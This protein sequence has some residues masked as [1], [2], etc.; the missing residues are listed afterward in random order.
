[1]KIYLTAMDVFLYVSIVFAI[2]L[3]KEWNLIGAAGLRQYDG[4]DWLILMIGVWAQSGITIKA[5]FDKSF[6]R[7]SNK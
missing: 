6:L 2:E 1:M 4:Y 5:Y 7:D 3:A